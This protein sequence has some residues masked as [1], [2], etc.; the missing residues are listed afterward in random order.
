[1]FDLYTYHRSTLL[2]TLW[3]PNTRSFS[4]S[5]RFRST[6]Y[7]VLRWMVFRSKFCIY[8]QDS[9]DYINFPN[10]GD[11]KI[12]IIDYP[13]VQY[14]PALVTL[15]YIIK[16]FGWAKIDSSERNLIEIGDLHK[17]AWFHNP[18]ILS[19]PMICFS[20]RNVRISQLGNAD[21]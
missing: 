20:P 19:K 9:F 18:K 10:Q 5:S 4:F 14:K 16:L 12:N 17:I 21:E 13:G 6:S 3:L 2:G 15:F 11:P 7:L 8:R 1:M